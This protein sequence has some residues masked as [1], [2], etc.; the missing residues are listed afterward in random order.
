ME[1]GPLGTVEVGAKDWTPG[2]YRVE[3][4]DGTQVLGR[5]TLGVMW[6]WRLKTLLL[7]PMEGKLTAGS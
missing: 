6:S 4:E 1:T 7:S 3:V 2:F 5:G